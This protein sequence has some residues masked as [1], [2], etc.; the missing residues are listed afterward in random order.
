[1]GDEMAQARASDGEFWFRTF[2]AEIPLSAVVLGP[3]LEILQFNDAAAR[4]LGYT[5]E[6]FAKLTIYDI[7]AAVSP[8][9]L[10]EITAQR[11]A[12]GDLSPLVTKHRTKAGE[13]RDI[14][15]YGTHFHDQGG[16]VITGCVWIDV[17][18][19]K[20]AETALL[21]SERHARE[22]EAWFHTLFDTIP[23]S[24]AIID[25]DTLRFLQFNDVAAETLG[26]TREEFA[27]LTVFDL[28]PPSP[29]NAISGW[30]S[31]CVPARRSCSRQNIG[32]S[33]AFHGT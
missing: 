9:Q 13:L 2:V 15:L 11:R 26:Y 18:E 27:K 30:W 20:A 25:P 29:S 21:E 10:R 28:D 24:A 23:L 22:Q 32:P 1:M 12:A 33:P 19:Q 7:E 14:T 6:E 16:R 3:D 8:Q 17:T 4:N 5:R 31:D